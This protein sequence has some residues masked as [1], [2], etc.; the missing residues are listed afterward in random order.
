L[1]I[2]QF[3]LDKRPTPTYAAMQQLLQRTIHG[4]AKMTNVKENIEMMNEMGSNSYSS[5]RQL[6]EINLNTWNKLMQNQMAMVTTLM[7]SSIG[8]LKLMTEAKDYHEVSRSQI[9]LAQK[10]G[11]LFMD[12]TREN[13]EL[14]QKAGEDYR[15]WFE[16]SMANANEQFAKAAEKAA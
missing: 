2:A 9:D 5:L 14:A 3:F 11:G 1:C 12:K 10:L 4:S 6:G 15:L 16:G 13:I 8:Q 7:E